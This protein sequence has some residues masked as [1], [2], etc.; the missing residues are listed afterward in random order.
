[1]ACALL[2]SLGEYKNMALLPS[3][4]ADLDTMH[5]LCRTVLNIDETKIAMKTGELEARFFEMVVTQFCIDNADE[6][7]FIFYYSGHGGVSN[8]GDN[9]DFSLY[10]TDGKHVTLPSVLEKFEDNFSHGLV[11]LD[12]CSS[13]SASIC[14]TSCDFIER[15][16]TGYTLFASSERGESSY[17]DAADC[18]SVFTGALKIAF[19]CHNET[20]SPFYPISS[21]IETVN[22]AMGVKNRTMQNKSMHPVVR[23]LYA[24]DRVF[25]SGYRAFEKSVPFHFDKFKYHFAVKN[26]NSNDFR[27][28]RVS[29]LV[30]EEFPNDIKDILSIIGSGEVLGEIERNHLFA[31]EREAQRLTGKPLTSIV[32]DI[33]SHSI[34]LQVNN[35]QWR[36]YWENDAV[37]HIRLDKYAPLRLGSLSYEK[38]LCYESIR[39]NYQDHSMDK[40]ALAPVLSKTYTR[41]SFLMETIGSAYNRVLNGRNDESSLVALCSQLK[42]LVD[43]VTA[44]ALDLP[45]STDSPA[46]ESDINHLIGMTGALSNLVNLYTNSEEIDTNDRSRLRQARIFLGQCGE[47]HRGIFA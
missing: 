28:V 17:A 9:G 4:R 32:F 21:V 23:N 43:T 36:A 7:A 20:N 35:P 15:S 29:V 22:F 45:Y 5:K 38:M 27:R 40:A 42:T 46:L 14:D 11:I 34:D 30:D 6:D 10:G 26:M 47:S 8:T 33:F 3:A 19:D 24:C 18:P 39:Q 37:P 44:D 16:S 12:S 25:N 13:G 2:I 1:M 41:A 31:N